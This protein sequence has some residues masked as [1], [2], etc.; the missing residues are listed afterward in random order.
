ML[1]FHN[2]LELFIGLSGLAFPSI[3][4]IDCDVRTGNDKKGEASLMECEV[5]MLF[6]G[7]CPGRK[8]AFAVRNP[9][10]SVSL[11]RPNLSCP[12]DLTLDTRFL[13]QLF[14]AESKESRL[15]WV[16]AIQYQLAVTYPDV[17]FPPFEY[18]PPTG[19]H[20]DD[21]VLLCG[22]LYKLNQQLTVRPCLIL[23]RVRVTVCLSE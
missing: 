3:T 19:S 21:R 12:L 23:S 15:R 7:E 13:V 6:N 10:G 20:P 1:L 14:D 4:L 17:N 22:D 8:F 11:V 18:G 16:T 5:K 2:K 9:S